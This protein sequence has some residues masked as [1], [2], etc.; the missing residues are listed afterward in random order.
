MLRRI[1]INP[2]IFTTITML[3]S[4]SEKTSKLRIISFKGRW[5]SNDSRKLA[6]KRPFIKLPSQFIDRNTFDNDMQV[7]FLWMELLY[8]A[9]LMGAV[10]TSTLT[11]EYPLLCTFPPFTRRLN[12][13]IPATLNKYTSN[14]SVTTISSSGSIHP[15]SFFYRMRH[16]SLFFVR[17]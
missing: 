12:N 13:M 15:P 8:L 5:F 17:M 16:L 4:S 10:Y 9:P 6:T 1:I 3:F 7:V 14:L 11:H 2:I